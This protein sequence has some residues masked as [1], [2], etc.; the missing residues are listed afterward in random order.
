MPARRR[1]YDVVRIAGARPEEAGHALR[2]AAAG[3]KPCGEQR[4]RSTLQKMSSVYWHN[5]IPSGAL[6]I[7]MAVLLL[8]FLTSYSLLRMSQNSRCGPVMKLT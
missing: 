3:V 7:C 5:A 1:K 2:M 4:C 6:Q 8:H